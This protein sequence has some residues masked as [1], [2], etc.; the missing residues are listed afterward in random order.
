MYLHKEILST[1][2]CLL[3]KAKTSQNECISNIYIFFENLDMQCLL[4]T[5]GI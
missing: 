4:N 2:L 1:T 3:T 5:L